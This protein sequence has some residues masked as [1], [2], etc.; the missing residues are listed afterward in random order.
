MESIVLNELIDKSIEGDRYTWMESECEKL[1]KALRHQSDAKKMMFFIQPEYPAD[2]AAFIPKPMDYV[3]VNKRLQ[4][5]DYDTF[6]EIISD[7]RLIFS[8]ALKYNARAKGTQSVSGLA[9]DGA[10]YMSHKLEAAIDKMM[11]SVS[12]RIERERI[13][14]AIAEREIDAAERAEEEKMRAQW[15]GSSGAKPTELTAGPTQTTLHI[16]S[17]RAPK[18]REIRGFDESYFDDDEGSHEQSYIDLMRLQK[19]IY[20]KQKLERAALDANAAAIGA[21]VFARLEEQK[22]KEASLLAR[23]NATKKPTVETSKP[24]EQMQMGTAVLAELDRSDRDK[25][26]ITFAIKPSSKKTATKKKTRPFKF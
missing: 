13:E 25:I 7:L 21:A 8:N 11:I 19:L 18:R 6:G 10:V 26:K 20:E 5:R 3:R 15:T 14:H 17:R 9:Y 24:N 4:K 22:Q 23:K 2:Y 16:V 12:D 1:L